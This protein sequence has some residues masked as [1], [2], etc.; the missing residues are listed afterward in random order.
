MIIGLRQPFRWMLARA[1]AARRERTARAIYAQIGGGSPLLAN[2]RAQA[3][4]LQDLLN[5]GRRNEHRCFVMMRY[6][7]PGC[8]RV[9][10]EI[11]A[12]APDR[13]VLLPLYPQFSTPTV[14]PMLRV[15]QQIGRASCGKEVGRK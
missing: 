10:S 3:M 7:A 14:G 13:I 5:G 1:I 2:T 15:W 12:W 11:V 4:A 9:M 6:S 8:A